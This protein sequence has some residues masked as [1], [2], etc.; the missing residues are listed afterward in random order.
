MAKRLHHLSIAV[1]NIEEALAFYCNVLGLT[2]WDKSI[3]K[4]PERGIKVVGLDIGDISI[5][6]AQPT[7]SE[8]RHARF[9]KE[10]GEGLFHMSISTDDFDAEVTSLKEK[11]FPVV[12]EEKITSLFP[13]YT[14]RLA[15][16]P[17]EA[18]RGALVQIVDSASDPTK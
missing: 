14:I 7:D 11:G 3:T 4:V 15:W 2:P 10:R 6:L 12:E 1:N 5:H 17:P 8:N 18:T 13:G 9:L 16:L